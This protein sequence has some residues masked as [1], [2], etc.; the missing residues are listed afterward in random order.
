MK[1]EICALSSSAAFGL[2]PLRVVRKLDKFARQLFAGMRLNA[3]SDLPSC[4]CQV[5]GYISCLGNLGQV[6][7][8]CCRNKGWGST[9]ISRTVVKELQPSDPA[10]PPFA[11]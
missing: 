5:F 11:A 1:H 10:W 8:L 9:P 2:E 4:R 7:K 3:T 6:R